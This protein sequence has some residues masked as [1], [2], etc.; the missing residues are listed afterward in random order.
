MKNPTLRLHTELKNLGL[1]LNFTVSGEVS[2]TLLRYRLNE[3]YRP[4]IDVIW[5]MKLS[6][7][8]LESIGWALGLDAVTASNLP[9][10]GIE[11][12]RSNPTTKTR[13]ADL[14][15]LL[16][17]GMPLGIIATSEDNEPG[18][19]RRTSRVILTMKHY[20]GAINSIPFEEKWLTDLD[21]LKWEKGY[22]RRPNVAEKKPRG[23]E[24]G[25]SLYV[26][27]II[28]KRGEDAGFSVEESYTPASLQSQYE[29][30]LA[31][32]GKR[33]QVTWD[34]VSGKTKDARSAKQYLT[35]CE[36]DLA[37]LLPLPKSFR[38]FLTKID[39]Y[40]PN[41]RQQGL[42][43]PEL[44]TSIPVVGFEIESSAGK[45]A[46]G[47]FLNLSAYSLLG[48]VV[49]NSAESVRTLKATLE[50]YRPTLGLRNIY[51]KSLPST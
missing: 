18:G 43:F 19:Y 7:S 8:M 42:L 25:W 31:Q 45:H 28:R 14:A 9:I 34:P 50:T 32:T 24:K 22:C 48:V 16:S 12:E 46:A 36:I 1:K 51:V 13:Q 29:L 4:R 47:G 38:E 20:Y 17:V 40:D 2:D 15:N 49:S 5:S 39:H 26:R 41:L 6:K 30:F 3:G 27:D 23:G 44:W 33:P 37:W 35:G 10:V 21:G 11:V